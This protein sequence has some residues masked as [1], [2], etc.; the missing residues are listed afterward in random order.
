MGFY[1]EKIFP[2]LM[3]RILDVEPVSEQRRLALAPA[4][5]SILEIGFGTGLN[6]PCYPESVDKIAVLD[7]NPGMKRR[8][9][10]RTDQL[11]IEVERY[12]MRSEKLMFDDASFDTVVSTFTFCS[13]SDLNQALAELKRVLKPDGQ[14]L[15]LEHGLSPDRWVSYGQRFLTPLQKHIG[16]GCHL[17]RD[18]PRM[19]KGQGFR[20]TELEQFYLP[21]LPKMGGYISRG[22]AV[23]N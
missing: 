13:I 8:A 16:D 14:L 3:D 2:G 19:I 18:I 10:E 9:Q 5:G 6:L 15:F 21:P 7:P 17:D 4:R 23:P 12:L 1:S 20:I 11:S 22:R